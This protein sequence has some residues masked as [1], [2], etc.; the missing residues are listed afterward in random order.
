MSSFSCRFCSR[1]FA[2][3]SAYSQHVDRCIPSGNISHG[4]GS[5]FNIEKVKD[6]SDINDLISETSDNYIDD[7]S[8]IVSEGDQS[9]I[10]SEGDQSVI[11]SEGDQ[12]MMVSEGDQS[13][14]EG[15]QSIQISEDDQSHLS[16][17]ISE[18]GSNE[19]I[20]KDI[21]EPE[22]I[23]SEANIYYPNEAYADLMTLVTKC[24]LSNST[25][26][27]IIKFFNKHANLSTSPLPKSIEIG[28]KY[29]D[30]MDLPNLAFNKTYVTSYDNNDYYLHHRSLIKCIKSILSIPNI[31][32][33]FTLSF[34][35][36]EVD[37]ERAYSE[38]NTAIW[39]EKTEKSLPS[40]SKLLSIMLYS[41]ATNVDTLGKS[42]LHPIYL[43]IGNIK[44]WRRNKPDAKQLLG[45]LPILKSNEKKTEKFKIASR[46]AFHK[47]L[48]IM[49]EPILTFKNGIEL[50]LDSKSICFYPRISIII[51]DWPEAATYCLTYK[52]AM[53]NFPCHFCLVAR[54]NLA[55]IHLTMDKMELRTHE[56]MS[57]FF[58]QNLEKSVCIENAYNYFWDLP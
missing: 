35:N 15:G 44:T 37:G 50:T 53:S 20:F 30:N 19:D 48:E 27:A 45:F 38:Q 54:D 12:S 8:M 21:L 33:N 16:N 4:E 18:I 17:I 36:F 29:M 31:S 32:Q 1:T 47:S 22:T 24:K 28:R 39:W 2:N 5:I 46:K 57:S 14:S 3:R 56:K 6:K 41:D 25:G 52:S 23:E 26:N 43:T 51:S 55:D 34:E 40:G 58:E 10:V 49:L 11:V 7:Q 42:N 9:M 13:I